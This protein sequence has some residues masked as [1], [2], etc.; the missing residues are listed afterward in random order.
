MVERYGSI[1]QCLHWLTALL[2]L[3]MIPMGFLLGGLPEGPVQN[4][5]Y[6]LHRSCGIVLLLLTI[7]RLINR[8]FN[9]P[10][11]E[12]P[13]IGALQLKLAQAMHWLLYAFL[14]GMPLL[15]WWASSAYGAP[16]TFFWLFEMPRIAAENKPAA[17]AAFQLHGLGGF[18]LSV[19]LVGH[20]G[21]ALHHH[22]F[23][24][25]DTLRRMLPAPRR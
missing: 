5:A 19:L 25:D 7:L 14:F 2:V 4:T 6:D 24:G 23:R 10:P 17:E 13:T 3:G 18:V 20:A 8:L 1:A 11:P 22:F 9:R 16:T 12:D 15:G 21:A